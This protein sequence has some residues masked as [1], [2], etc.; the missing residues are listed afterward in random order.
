MIEQ[1]IFKFKTKKNYIKEDYYVTESNKQAFETINTWPK[2]IKRVINVYG[3]SGSGKSHLTSIFSEK[4]PCYKISSKNLSNEIFLK[5]KLKEALII[6]DFD[7]QTSEELL[8][9]IFN[10]VE[11]D[12]KYMLITSKTPISLFNFKLKDL[13]SR[14]R[15]STIIEIKLPSDELIKVILAKNFS[16]K[17]IIIDKKLINYI[18]KTTDRS[19]EKISQFILNLDSYS[20]KKGKPISFKIVKEVIN[21]LKT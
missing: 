15:S 12:N 7:N 19:Y 18:I 2:W 8:Y 1:L 16:D 14:A 10:M 13:K 5:F 17:Q 20:L 4:V 6:E 3:P 9:S 21:M 11:Q